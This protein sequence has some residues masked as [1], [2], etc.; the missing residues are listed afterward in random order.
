MVNLTCI[1]D[2]MIAP[3]SFLKNDKLTRGWGAGRPGV[4]MMALKARLSTLA[5][6]FRNFSAPRPS[7]LIPA[8]AWL[9]Y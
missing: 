5:K 8:L 7:L 3:T 1:N 6:T 4:I 2:L 9:F